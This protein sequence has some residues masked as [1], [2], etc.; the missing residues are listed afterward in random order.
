MNNLKH[1]LNQP[2]NA[3]LTKGTY[4]LTLIDID[5]PNVPDDK[6]PYAVLKFAQ[7]NKAITTKILFEKDLEFMVYHG[8]A[9]YNIENTNATLQYVIELMKQD[10]FPVTITDVNYTALDGTEKTTKNWYF[11][12]TNTPKVTKE[13]VINEK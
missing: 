8:K 1:L 3:T 10:A 13:S 6:T 11:F 5:F 12:T 7:P 2:T 4:T 9:Y